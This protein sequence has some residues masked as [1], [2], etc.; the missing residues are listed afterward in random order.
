[1]AQ[2]EFR[3]KLGRIRD[4]ASNAQLRTNTQMLRETGRAGARAVRQRGH[5]TSAMPKRG[6][7][8]GVRAAAGLISPGSRRV[9]VKARYTRITA[10]DMGAARAH[11]KYIQRDGVT[12]DGDVGRL[13]DAQ[14]DDVDGRAFLE[15]SENDPHQ[16][17]FIVSAEDSARLSDLKPFIRDL[18]AQMERDLDTKLDWVAV[19]HFNTGHPH[20]HVVIRG[21]D[22]RGQDLVMARD[23]IG[24]GVRARAQALVTL[25]LG[26]ETQLERIQKLFDEVG[27]ERLTRLDR[28]LMARAKD[29]I[30]VITATEENDPTQRTLRIG[31]LRT[32]QRLGLASERQ[33][34]IWSLDANAEAKL[35]QLG[36]RADKFKMM[37]RALKEAGIERG[38]AAMALFERGPRKAPLVGKVVGVGMVDEITD[39]TWVIIDAIDGRVHYA[40]LGRL[41]AEAVPER[42]NIVALAGDGLNEKPSS[43]PRLHL[44]SA[45]DLDR[46]TTYEGPTWLDEAIVTRWQPE[47]RTTGFTAEADKALKA[48]TDWLASR[49]LIE[50]SPDGRRVPRADMMMVLRQAETQHL[51]ADVSRRL[52]AAFVP[53]APGARITGTYDH[54]ITTP[55]GKIAVI[56]RED[57]FT[58]APWQPALEPFRGQAVAGIVGPSRM[59]WVH[60]RGRGLP[61]RA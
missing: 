32:L 38:A 7:G 48:R 16:F 9:I 57:T 5:I 1:M 43:V 6:M 33:V 20:T 46:Q 52:N 18:F 8:A 50:Q 30:L 17:R 28:Q 19:D 3:P 11:L 29:N 61:G 14:Q 23:Y 15:R 34:G 13:Y 22:D 4:T 27:Q 26:P 40:D 55:T 41:K 39:R 58:L 60:S 31:R 56:R 35:R 12:R 2:D 25:E 47:I 10:G 44:L 42:G 51:A 24:H 49:Q 53:P 37:Q 54:A 36:D 59:T 45:T 21:R